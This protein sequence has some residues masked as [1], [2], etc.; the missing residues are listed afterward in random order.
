VLAAGADSTLRQARLFD[1]RYVCLMRRDHP[2]AEQPLTLDAYCAAHHLLASATGRGQ[3]YV[4]QALTAL[5]RQRRVVLT[6][7]QYF[8][9]GRVV[10]HS[11]L[12]TVL[13]RVFIP[14]TGHESELLVRELPFDLGAMQVT[15]LWHM[16]RDAEPAHRWLRALVQQAAQASA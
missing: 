7:N 6:V 9:A 11:D 16:R 2:L 4:D 5:G 13:P 8:T 12:L 10:T 15:M 3:G 1:T 14:A